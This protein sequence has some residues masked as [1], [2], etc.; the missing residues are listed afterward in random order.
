VQFTVKGAGHT[1]FFAEDEVVFAAL[2]PELTAEDAKGRGLPDDDSANPLAGP[3]RAAVKSVVRL[4]FPGANPH[5]AVEGLE[6]LPGAA[7][8]F[9]G[10]DP[11]RWQVNLP[12][13]GAWSIAASTPA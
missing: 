10:N 4:R 5:P 11:A 3:G 1:L 6:P 9:L 12:T 8:F 13:Y 2:R 7:N